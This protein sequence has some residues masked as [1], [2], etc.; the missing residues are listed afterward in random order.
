MND[1][2]EY[3]RKEIMGTGD[4]DT[5]RL[6]ITS[7]TGGS[8]W[9]SITGAQRDAIADVLDPRGT[10]SE[11]SWA[12]RAGFL[13]RAMMDI[14]IAVGLDPEH[15]TTHQTVTAVRNL[16]ARVRPDTDAP[17]PESAKE[18]AVGADLDGETVT[19]TLEGNHGSVYRVSGTTEEVR[20]FVQDA[21]DAV[22]DARPD[23]GYTLR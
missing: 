10:V 4:G 6:K 16:A 23:E 19:L 7:D 21:M 8:K 14:A 18:I 12:N 2:T 3:Q 15:S 1:V 13:E 17:E 11:A 22:R 9:L 20:T 5:F